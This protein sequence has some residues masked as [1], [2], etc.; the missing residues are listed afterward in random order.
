MDITADRLAS[1]AR[2]AAW[3]SWAAGLVLSFQRL[4]LSLPVLLAITFMSYAG[5]DAASGTPAQDALAGALR[6][7]AGYVSRLAA[8]DLGATA[9]DIYSSAPQPLAVLVPTLLVKSLGLLAAATVVAIALGLPLGVL[10]A[11]RRHSGLSRLTVL[12]SIVGISLPSFFAAFLL[13]LLT[14]RLTRTLG[15]RLLPV[16]GFGWDSH[17]VLPALV[18][19][20]RP[21]AQIARVTFV[22]LSSVLERDFVRTAHG[23]GLSYHTVLSRHVLRNAAIP[24]LTTLGMSARFSLSSLPVVEYFFGWPGLGA[25]LLLAIASRDDHLTVTLL[26]CLGLLFLLINLLL[27]LAYRLADPQLRQPP[28]RISQA[29]RVSLWG[30]LLSI[31]AD[32]RDLLVAPLHHLRRPGRPP[33]VHNGSNTPAPAH[34]EHRRRAQLRLVLGNTEFVLGTLIVLGLIVLVLFGP[35]LAPHSPYTTRGISYHDGVLSAPPFAPG[36]DYLWGTDMLGRDLLSLILAGAQQTIVVAAAVVAARMAVGSL[37]GLVSGWFRGTWADRLLL[38]LAE[39]IAA[40][41]A[42]LLAMV[43]ILALG[44]RRGLPPFILALGF[45]GW[46]EVMQL[47][48]AETAALRPRPF[49]EGAVATG[50]RPLRLI[51]HH[52]L[53]NLAPGLISIAALEMGSVLMLLGELGFLGIF[54]GGGVAAEVSVDA[55]WTYSDV[56][57]WGALLSNVRQYARAYPWIALYP[58]LAFF[59]AILGFNLF[60]EG[61]RR[62]VDQIGINLTRLLNRYTLALVVVAVVGTRW[63]ADNLGAIATYRQQA[64]TFSGQAALAHVQALAAPEMDGRALSTPGMDAAVEY[65]AAQFQS[66]GLQAAGET[67]TYFQPQTRSYLALDAVPTL[68]IADGGPAPVYHRDYVEAPWDWQAL[69]Q[70]RGEVRLLAL[71]ELTQARGN[72]RLRNYYTALRNRDHSDEIVLVLSPEDAWH[73]SRVP[74]G[75]ILV[76]SDDPMAPQRRQTLSPAL[77]APADV[78]ESG[79]RPMLYISEETADRLLAGT[80]HTISELRRRAETLGL[81]EI[82]ELPLGVEAE[83][84]VSGQVV[85]KVP[86]R[87]VI[88]HLPGT[89]PQWDERLIVVLAQY[90][91]PAPAPDG[92]LCPGATDNAS[93]VGVMLEVIRTLQESGYQPYKSFLFVA[94]SGEGYEGSEPV[95]PPDVRTFLE[96]KRGFSTAFTIEGVV[97][98]RGLGAGEGR[99]LSITTGGNERLAELFEDSARQMGVPASRAREASEVRLTFDDAPRAPGTGP[100]PMSIS[101]DGFGAFSSLPSDTVEQVSA[102]KL[103]AA[104]RAIA[105]ALMK[106]GRD[107][108]R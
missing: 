80:G 56:P 2:P 72:Y 87:N 93:G 88:A 69:G 30:G 55:M 25:G 70:A 79:Q 107:A 20:A 65:V 26:L 22:S 32:L 104:G 23:K 42:L 10:A 6:Q 100:Q 48:R 68:S 96:S 89:S 28:T 21:L 106:M 46:G 64:A 62:L 35:R 29:D 105:L 57:E 39:T 14:I 24:I 17:L 102:D 5:L 77:P 49:I 34:R 53:P 15:F 98:L 97:D 41:P 78:G 52:A 45:V 91:A 43:L 19:A 7:T 86:V 40:F 59:T 63:A 3:Q 95:L 33:A 27:E 75:G 83:V 94:Y 13:Q 1:P 47:V 90:D 58:A 18:L 108:T 99:G 36:P 31:L 12:A 103:E 44:I 50:L 4:L 76:V 85:P 92:I 82:L 66:L 81:D 8:G 38:G 101:W 73:L 67:F 84:A 9:T 16:G 37:L 54:I 74:I 11:L 61:V 60:G 51:L 71:G